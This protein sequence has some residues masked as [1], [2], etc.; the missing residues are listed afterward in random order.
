MNSCPIHDSYLSSRFVPRL[1]TPHSYCRNAPSLALT[2]MRSF[3]FYLVH[4]QSG[5]SLAQYSSRF[6]A[7]SSVFTR[8]GAINLFAG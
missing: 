6:S 1:R 4:A 3:P 5:A 7:S 8:C 2:R